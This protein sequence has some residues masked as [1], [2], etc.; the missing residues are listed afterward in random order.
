MSHHFVG[1]P[2]SS[3]G[4]LWAVIHELKR[5][6]DALEAAQKSAEPPISR[7]IKMQTENNPLPGFEE[8]QRGARDARLTALEAGHASDCAVHNE[9]ALAA[10]QCNCKSAPTPD[11]PREPGWYPI[12]SGE[13]PVNWRWTGDF[14]ERGNSL[15]GSGAFPPEIIGPRI[16]EPKE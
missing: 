6:V 16:Q 9:P 11:K 5:R 4:Q 8:T 15:A 3:E 7:R 12:W 1:S 2:F 13:A 14:W 10:G